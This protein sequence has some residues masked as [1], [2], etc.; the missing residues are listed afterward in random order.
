MTFARGG[1]VRGSLYAIGKAICIIADSGA[2]VFPAPRCA[3]WIPLARV[4]ACD[5]LGLADD[6][7][8]YYHFKLQI[9]EFGIV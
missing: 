8:T 2:R 4:R 9:R 1:G 3:N 6:G 7:I 5:A